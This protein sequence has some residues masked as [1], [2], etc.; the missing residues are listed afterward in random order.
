MMDVDE[1]KFGEEFA[2]DLFADDEDVEMEELFLH[3]PRIA[4]EDLFEELA[5][6]TT[7]PRR[8]PRRGAGWSCGDL[9]GDGLC[10]ESF[11]EDEGTKTT[12]PPSADKVPVTLGTIQWDDLQAM[13]PNK[14]FAISIE[15]IVRRAPQVAQARRVKG[16][17]VKPWRYELAML[18][19]DPMR[20]L[21]FEMNARLRSDAYYTMVAWI[22]RLSGRSIRVVKQEMV[23]E[24]IMKRKWKD[25]D[26]KVKRRFHFLREIEKEPSFQD[27]F[28]ELFEKRVNG[29][30]SAMSFVAV[31]ER[32][33]EPLPVTQCHGY[34]AT[35]NTSLG[36]Q[37]SEV[38]EWVQQGLRGE[39]LAIKLKNHDLHKAAFRRFV[40][41]H[42]D[43]ADKHRF[44]TWAV[45][46]EHSA[47]ANHPARVHLHV[48]AGVDIRGG[49][50]FMGLPLTR[51][52]SKVSLEWPGCGPPHVNFTRIKRPSPN[53]ILNGVA[54]GMY[55]VAG[56]KASNL[57]LEASMQPFVDR[58]DMRLCSGRPKTFCHAFR[59][60]TCGHLTQRCS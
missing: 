26:D 43:L 2:E 10:L 46:L 57:M 16:G 4:L 44:K 5:N 12:A 24:W 39:D 53:N 35:Y 17:K 21:N 6:Q 45:A 27:A 25:T 36:L 52:V 34:L 47:H 32:A 38:M 3:S 14:I 50:L 8:N 41:F 29:R 59:V 37:D 23:D 55:Y 13:H 9:G 58:V 42:K 60:Q 56:A 11:F 7:T 48:Y 31:G 20:E 18:A 51:P 30:A 49:H 33:Q 40:T 22:S 15:Y 54:T 19:K 1:F 28:P